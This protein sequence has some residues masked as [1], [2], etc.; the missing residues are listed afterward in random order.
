MNMGGYS[1]DLDKLDSPAQMLSIMLYT[2]GSQAVMAKS[3]AEKFLAGGPAQKDNAQIMVTTAGTVAAFIWPLPSRRKPLALAF[4]RRGQDLQD[5]LGLND[6]RLSALK[7]L[8]DGM[9][10]LD[11]RIEE[12]WI[13]NP[14]RQMTMWMATEDPVQDGNFMS[15]NPVAQ[16][17]SFLEHE[18]SIPEL[19][20]ILN[21]IQRRSMNA[22]MLMLHVEDVVTP[23]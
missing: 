2:L 9:I 5:L 12:S 3:A 7:G 23:E 18:V 10:H 11:E 8:R 19:I 1:V 6:N 4:P 16:V 22:F 13:I 20:E 21:I 17:F 15:W 14:G